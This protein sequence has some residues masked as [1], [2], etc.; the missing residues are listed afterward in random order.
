MN[1]IDDVVPHLG[2]QHAIS[3]VHKIIETG[4]G[5]DL[6]LKVFEDAGNMVNVVDHIRDKFLKGIKDVS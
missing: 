6:Q 5:A 2:S 1:F 4:T 3:H